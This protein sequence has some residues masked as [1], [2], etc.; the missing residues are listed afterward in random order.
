MYYIAT[1]KGFVVY[2]GEKQPYD[3][4]PDS[5]CATPFSDF[6]EADALAKECVEKCL[7]RRLHYFSI[8]D[9]CNGDKLDNDPNVI[10]VTVTEVSEPKQI[11]SVRR[12]INSV[13][14]VIE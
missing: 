12:L 14:K 13:R 2:P 5:R 10:D 11:G 3:F 8:L 9:T 7:P 4:T 1:A 6:M